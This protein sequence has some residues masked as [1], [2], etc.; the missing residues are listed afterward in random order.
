MMGNLLKSWTKYG[1]LGRVVMASVSN[2]PTGS[3]T[4]DG[5][6]RV[7]SNLTVVDIVFAGF[8]TGF[9][10]EICISLGQSFFGPS[11]IKA[12]A[13]STL[14]VISLFTSS[15]PQSTLSPATLPSRT[16]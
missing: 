5:I 4:A 1:Q 10:L 16:L 14:Q 3:V 9:L 2:D 12:V 13:T 15:S 7:S 11:F 6:S 8:G